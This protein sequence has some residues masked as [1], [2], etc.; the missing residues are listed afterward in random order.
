MFCVGIPMQ[1]ILVSNF[2]YH[3]QWLSLKKSQGR[4]VSPR[5]ERHRELDRADPDDV[6]PGVVLAHPMF[7][8][9]D[10]AWE[11]FGIV[12][13]LYAVTFWAFEGLAQAFSCFPNVIYGLF[14][15]LNIYFCGFPL[16]RHV[17][18]PGGCGLAICV[19]CY[20]LPLGWTLQSYMYRLWHHMD[21]HKGVTYCSD[22][23]PQGGV[24][25]APG[26]LLPEEDPSGA[27]ATAGLATRSWSRSPCSSPSSRLR[28]TTPATSASSSP[29]DRCAAS[30]TSPRCTS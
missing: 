15:F 26:L 21:N 30:G 8:L 4:H 22:A 10:L 12:L 6:H 3:Y 5:R 9:G 29:L 20:F 25:T 2:I 18:G 28:A 27:V 1:F 11:S 17:R 14:M 7:A 13:V 19:F 23:L 16:L 24:C